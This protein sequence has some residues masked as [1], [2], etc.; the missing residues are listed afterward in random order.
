[1]AVYHV[2]CGS[3][4]GRIYAGTVN[5]KGDKWVNKNDVTEE[6]LGAVRDHLLA[7]KNLEENKDAVA[8]GYQWETDN[9]KIIT[10]QL[11]VKDKEEVKEE[12]ETE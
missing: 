5:K 3:L 10:L 6:A 8:I 11:V 1:M 9:N 12:N 7:A 4:S 2:G